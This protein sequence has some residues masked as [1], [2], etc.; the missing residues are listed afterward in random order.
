IIFFW[1]A[2]MMMMQYAMVG[3]RPFDAVYVHALVRDAAGNK[4][5]K[6]LGNVIDPIELVDRFGADAVRFTLTSMAAMGRDLKLSEGRVAGYRNFTTKLWNAARFA[7]L[8]GVFEVEDRTPNATQTVNKWIIGEFA[9]TRIAVDD[10]LDGFRFNDA[11]NA[12][13]MFVWGTFC[14]WYV[15]FSKPLFNT[16]HAEEA[17]RTMAWLLD[18]CLI[19]LHPF[20]PFITEELW[21]LSAPTREK[22]LV[23]A[24]WPTCGAELVDAEAESE[25]AWVIDL[26]EKVR[27]VRG[28]MNVPA[29]TK[30]QLLKLSLDAAGETAWANNE[31]MIM[32]QARIEAL[33]DAD[34]APKGS[35]TIAALGGTF[36]LPLEGLIDVAVE[37]KRLEKAVGKLERDFAGLQGR[38][39]NRKFRENA[40]E[41]VIAETEEAATQKAEELGRLRT[42]LGR[43]EELD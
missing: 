17:R 31:S 43:I 28:E 2:R 10:A 15:E 18:Q 25:I 14:D 5:S 16:E 42:A 34:A 4:M 12:L 21:A 1:V 30:T 33:T 3:D 36:A 29:G 38:L 32:R 27:S 9:K 22:M 20:M 7:E 11:A 19:L 8:N 13:Y 23:H 24:D 40:A 37:R 26:V 6:S 39:D 41:D 35:A